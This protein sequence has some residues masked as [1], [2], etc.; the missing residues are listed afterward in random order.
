MNRGIKDIFASSSLRNYFRNLAAGLR[1]PKDSGAHRY[2]I[3]QIQRVIVPGVSTILFLAAL[4]TMAVIFGKDG[5]S[6]QVG[7]TD[8]EGRRVD[9]ITGGETDPRGAENKPAEK[10]DMAIQASDL[11][12]KTASWGEMGKPAVPDGAGADTGMPDSI[13]PPSLDPGLPP[14][15]LTKNPRL[16][17]NPYANRGKKARDEARIKYKEIPAGEDAVLRALR[18]LKTHQDEGGSW[19][20]ADAGSAHPHPSAMAGL[21]LLAFLAHDETS[22]YNEHPEF[23]PTVEKAIKYLLSTQKESGMFGDG[24]RGYGHAMDTYAISEAY[25][26]TRIVSLKDAVEKG[27]QIIIAGQQ[28]TGGYDYNYA[29]SDRF[30]LSVAGWQFQALKAAR[31]AGAANP[32]LDGALAKAVN[33]LERNAFANAGENAGFVYA[34]KPGV[35]PNGGATESMTG[36]G[37][38]C[39]QL[40]G[41]GNSPCVSVGI[42]YLERVQPQWPREQAGK[43]AKAPL[44]TWYYVTQAKFQKGEK[45][46][47]TWNRSFARELVAN[48]KSDG[49]WEGGDWGGS[50]Y[51]T[52][53]CTL[54]LEVY[55]RYLPSYHK[56]EDKTTAPEKVADDPAVQISG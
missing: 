10:N 27:I 36:A 45:V 15:G 32:G 28:G 19:T 11:T 14:G 26:M 4:I 55:Y 29:K 16:S 30:D 12:G 43:P 31:L 47:E 41:R 21:A 52:C 40:L 54:M 17:T 3:F 25:A 5:G 34:G 42:R 9:V 2:A 1:A 6:G 35:A 7:D 48:Q 50:V 20:R 13:V 23:A 56:Q 24:G 49:H 33:F 44:Y 38:L 46:W 37:T 22:D 51:S 18:W 8:S 53:L 39:L